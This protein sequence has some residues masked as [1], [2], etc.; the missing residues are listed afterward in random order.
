MPMNEN[1]LNQKPVL[2][3]IFFGCIQC[4]TNK[5]FLLK[6]LLVAKLHSKLFFIRCDNIIIHCQ[7]IIAVYFDRYWFCWEKLNSN[8]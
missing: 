7:L 2:L 6:Y 5:C 4:Q 8:N 1:I 3:E